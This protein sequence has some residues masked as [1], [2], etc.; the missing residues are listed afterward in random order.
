MQHWSAD[1]IM[2]NGVKIHVHRT[3]GDKPPLVLCH[4]ITDNGLCWTRAA[5]E[6]EKQYDVIMVD[7]RGH[8]LSD[9]PEGSYHADSHAADVVGL[10]QALG[11]EKPRLMG[12]SMGAATVATLAA[13]YPDVP[14]RIVLEDPPWRA[15]DR[16][17]E[18]RAAYMDEWRQMTVTRQNTKTEAEIAAEGRTANPK[19]DESEF[20]PWSHAKK[21]VNPQVFGF[22]VAP[23]P[24]LHWRVLVP[25]ITC[26]TLLVT[27]DPELGGIVTAEIAQE[28]TQAN[29]HIQT[30]Q[31]A[32]AGHNIRRDQFWPYV[33]LVLAFLAGTE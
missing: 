24:T 6:L 10:I 7:A 26:P 28:V 19:W 17:P 23:A 27:G 1:D 12:H 11:L 20:E 33:D 22:G 13:S 25:K 4:G 30:A 15:V 21:Q 14:S 31:I 5:G 3:G 18:E 29:G 2:V 9:A 16:S 8:G 32:N